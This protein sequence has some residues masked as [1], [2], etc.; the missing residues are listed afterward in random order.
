MSS[1]TDNPTM[2]KIFLT[3]LILLPFL[4]QAQQD[5]QYSQYMFNGLVINPAYAGS[6]GFF[7]A[8]LL[9]REQWMGLE[10]APSTQSFSFHGTSR[11]RRN[12][13]GFSLV[14]D[15]IGVTN[16]L[17]LNAAYAL[18]ILLGENSAISLG[19]QGSM[20]NYR[21]NFNDVRLDYGA[22]PQITD[23]AFT[24][25]EINRWLPNAGAGVYFQTPNFYLGASTPRIIQHD[26][27]QNNGSGSIA[28]QSPHYFF[29]T[30]AMFRLGD[31]VQLRPSV[32]AKYQP[33]APWQFDLNVHFLFAERLWLG[34]SYR[35]EDALIF[36]AE[37]QITKQFRIGYAYDMT[38]SELSDYNNGS[39]EFMLGF[40]FDFEKSKMVS[41]RY[42]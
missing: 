11:N 33:A 26:L 10:G 23:P 41:P 19:L 32:M 13:Y 29:T 25:N 5:P 37:L 4:G 9:A 2:K 18:R 36:M 16:N 40:D 38:T 34:A 22:D 3:I 28:K 31:N 1:S 27:T 15:K 7:S 39:H 14:N 20:T 6:R 17:N 30:G 42:F 8:T 35:T 12:G 24:G 21:A